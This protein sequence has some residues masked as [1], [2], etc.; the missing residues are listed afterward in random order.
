METNKKKYYFEFVGT[1]G[2]GKTFTYH[3]IAKQNLLEPLKAIYPGQ[4]Q[5]PKLHFL[6]S[7]PILALKNLNHIA[8]IS[9]F[10]LKNAEINFLNF[11][12]YRTLFKMII[13]HQYFFRF[14]FDVLL[15]DDMLHLIL[16]IIF[17]KNAD[18]EA[19]FREFFDH[20]KYLYDGFIFF[21]I[22]PD[23]VN[24]RFS[25]RFP[26]KSDSF[27]ASRLKIH[28]RSRQQSQILRRVLTSQDHIPFIVADGGDDV[29]V[30]AEK[31]IFFVK[32]TLQKT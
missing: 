21:D 27:I 4:V 13:L 32:T 23:V 15:K 20:F 1:H 25:K 24:E 3:V 10:M 31:I 2:A 5:R 28:Q 9:L 17:K 11:K 8:F 22:T 30:N 19:A 6:L 18:I 7:C 12:V 14:H 26:G 29:K 16:R